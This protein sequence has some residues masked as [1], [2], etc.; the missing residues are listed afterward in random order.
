MDPE[1]LVVAFCTYLVFLFS[2]VC[3]EAAHALAAKLGGDLTAY[4]GGQVSLNPVPHIRR[5]P[6]GLGLYP[7]LTL[8]LTGGTGIIG[9]AS[10]P[11]DPYWAMRNPRKAAWM[12]MA[13]PAANYVPIWSRVAT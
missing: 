7:L 5:E 1:I 10:A 11:Y 12:A 8:F 3:H 2:T 6:F 4:H 9:F 13:G